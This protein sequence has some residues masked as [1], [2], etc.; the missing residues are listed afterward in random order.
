MDKP[1]IIHVRVMVVLRQEPVSGKMVVHA[2]VPADDMTVLGVQVCNASANGDLV[3]VLGCTATLIDP[4]E[5]QALRLLRE[6]QKLIANST[7]IF[8]KTPD[9]S[10]REMLRKV[11]DLVNP[12]IPMDAK[13]KPL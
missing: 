4:L 2:V 11:E 1:S 13:L 10:A 7:L 12:A 5:S 6:I 3:Q 9:H 8:S